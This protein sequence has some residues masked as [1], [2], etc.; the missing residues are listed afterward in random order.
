MRAAVAVRRRLV[1][2]K[3]RGAALAVKEERHEL[4]EHGLRIVAKLNCGVYEA[5]DMLHLSQLGT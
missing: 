1:C 3:R 4:V 5:K 2:A